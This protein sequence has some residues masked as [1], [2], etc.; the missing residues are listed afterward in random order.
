MRRQWWNDLGARALLQ[1]IGRTRRQVAL[2]NLALCLPELPET[3]P[4]GAGG[5]ALLGAQALQD[6]TGRPCGGVP[7]LRAAAAAG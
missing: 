5:A 7:G 2:A 6:A 3:Q 4:P 1:V